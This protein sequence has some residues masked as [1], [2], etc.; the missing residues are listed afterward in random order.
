ML[1]DSV[2]LE[3][4]AAFIF[5]LLLAMLVIYETLQWLTHKPRLR[6]HVSRDS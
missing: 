2:S 4:I 1:A 6:G 5:A 3:S